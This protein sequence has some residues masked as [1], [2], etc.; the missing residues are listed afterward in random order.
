MIKAVRDMIILKVYHLHK[1]GDDTIYIP[2]AAGMKQNIMDYYG[3]V[4]SVGS[5]C[6]FALGEEIN[7]GDKLLFRR[8]EGHPIKTGD[9]KGYISINQKW[10]E[11]RVENV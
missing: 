9:W 2:D 8:N 7:I 5:E 1:I 6:R 11:G 10:I 3:E 4:I